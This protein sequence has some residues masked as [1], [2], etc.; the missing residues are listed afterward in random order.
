MPSIHFPQPDFEDDLITSKRGPSQSRRPPEKLAKLI[1]ELEVLSGLGAEPGDIVLSDAKVLP[2][3]LPSVYD[4]LRYMNLDAVLTAMRTSPEPWQF[5]PWGWSNTAIRMAAQLGLSGSEPVASSVKFVNSRQF[6][7]TLDEVIDI[8]SGEQTGL[9]G[10]LCVTVSETIS[11]VRRHG[12]NG[13][14]KW[15]IKANISHAARNRILG[16]GTEL[17]DEQRRW[18]EA[19]LADAPVYIEPWVERVAECGLQFEIAGRQPADEA[20]RFLGAAEMINDATG[21]YRGSVLRPLTANSSRGLASA[22]DAW[23]AASVEH[24]R[25]IALAAADQGFSGPMGIDCMLFRSE[26]RLRL[27]LAHDINGRRTMGRLALSLR[28]HLPSGHWGCWCFAS[29]KSAQ[30]ISEAIRES[31]ITSVQVIPTSPS[32]LSGRETT[33]RTCLLISADWAR[34]NQVA[35]KILSQDIRGP[36]CRDFPA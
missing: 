20:V 27:R 29:S 30:L 11:Q 21:Q 16:S 1:Q 15:V 14:G 3:E 23:W 26:G 5:K 12:A 17:R 7:A 2:A 4:G 25:R 18:L 31:S 36:F 24:G 28:R 33:L 8:E 10:R 34:L 13:N 6:S 35:Q 22:T 9:F 32:I 19:Q